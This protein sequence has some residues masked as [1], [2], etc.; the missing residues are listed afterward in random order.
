MSSRSTPG[1]VVSMRRASVAASCSAELAP[2]ASSTRLAHRR[3][4]SRVATSRVHMLK[5]R[6]AE[7]CRWSQPFA[8]MT[9]SQVMSAS[10]V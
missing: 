1:V 5:S 7:L 4:S 8:F 2:V 3:A 10:K 6:W 9:K